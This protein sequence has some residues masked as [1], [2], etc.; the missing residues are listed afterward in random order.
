LP[1]NNK[2]KVADYQTNRYAVSELI[3]KEIKFLFQKESRVEDLLKYS[4]IC[5]II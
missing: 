2:N 1:S 4:N 3:F 5:K